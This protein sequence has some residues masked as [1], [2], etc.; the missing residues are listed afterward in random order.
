MYC[1]VMATGFKIANETL[2]CIQ[3][4]HYILLL[5]LLLLMAVQ[6]GSLKITKTITAVFLH[7]PLSP[8]W[9]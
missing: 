5:L 6:S 7:V 9:V 3:Y 1:I 4:M 8:F 2:L